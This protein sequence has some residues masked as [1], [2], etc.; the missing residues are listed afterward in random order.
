MLF[1]G[2]DYWVIFDIVARQF[3]M[4]TDWGFDIEWFQYAF[5][6]MAALGYAVLKDQHVRIDLMT[7]RYPPRVQ[8]ALMAFSYAFF[9]LPLMI[10]VAMTSWE[11]A[12]WSRSVGEVTERPW[13]G[14]LWPIK[15]FIFTGI[16]LMLPQ[17]FAQLTRNI[18]FVIKKV[19]L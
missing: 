19:K 1:Y 14:P 12:S 15:Y 11:W 4:I 10:L 3:G 7:T 13:Y 6:L 2:I 16:M 17:V 8:A 5:I 18:V 9:V